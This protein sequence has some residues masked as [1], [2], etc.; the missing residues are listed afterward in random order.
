MVTMVM[1]LPP[2]APGKSTLTFN[3]T[4]T[5]SGNRM[6]GGLTGSGTNNET[7]TGIWA[8]NRQ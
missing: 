1:T 2:P 6:S 7:F 4:G 5:V 3:L 8:V